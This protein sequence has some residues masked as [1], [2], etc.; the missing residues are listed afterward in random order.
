MCGGGG[1]PS[2]SA[3]WLAV[4]SQL[5][6]RSTDPSGRSTFYSYILRNCRNGTNLLHLSLACSPLPAGTKAPFSAPLL[7]PHGEHKGGWHHCSVCSAGQLKCVPVGVWPLLLRSGT[8]QAPQDPVFR[9]DKT[10][11]Y[12]SQRSSVMGLLTPSFC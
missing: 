8:L 12:C 4:K 9:R 2:H 10:P 1:W 6:P 3:S 5:E 11:F 7:W